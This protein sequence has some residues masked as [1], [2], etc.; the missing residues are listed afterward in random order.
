MPPYTM[1]NRSGYGTSKTRGS[2]RN[3]RKYFRT[4]G[5]EG[6]SGDPRLTSRIPRLRMGDIL[7]HFCRSC[8]PADDAIRDGNSIAVTTGDEDPRRLRLE[9]AD[10]ILHRAV[11]HVV[12]WDRTRYAHD[13]CED[14]TA[15]HSHE[16]AYIGQRKLDQAGICGVNDVP[17]ARSAQVRRQQG[18]A[19]WSTV[20]KQGR[21][22]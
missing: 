5:T 14:R 3:S 7:K 19:L 15:Q 6:A 20:W 13:I 11:T 1:A 21:R 22:E 10:R 9:P 12:L 2:I 16:L 18:M 4:R 17:P 8:F